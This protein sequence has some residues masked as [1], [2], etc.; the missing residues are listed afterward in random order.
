MPGQTYSFLNVGDVIDQAVAE[1]IGSTASSLTALQDPALI[2]QTDWINRT[3]V[4]SA[5]TLADNNGFSWMVDQKHY[6]QTKDATSLSA[7]AAAG[8]TSITVGSTTDWP[9]TGQLYIR[10]A[11]DAVEFVTYS[12]IVGTTV[13]VSALSIA[14]AEGEHVELCYALPTS[15][16]KANTLLANTVE[17]FPQQTPDLPDWGCY[18][19]NGAFIVLPYDFGTEDMTLVYDK[20]PTALSTGDSTADRALSMNIPTEGFRYAVESL[21]AYIFTVR[22]KREDAEASRKAAL[23]NLMELL[24][25]DVSSTSSGGLR[26]NY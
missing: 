19:T 9:A 13:T 18:A 12:A 6:F 21:K 2:K 1:A 8:A 17:Y 4:N 25:Y 20:K 10:T 5:F 14:H 24:A 7:N 16:A 11:K 3:G 23:E 26:A 15:F 22:R